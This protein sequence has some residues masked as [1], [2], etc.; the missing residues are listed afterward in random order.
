[1]ET[2]SRFG[3]ADRPGEPWRTSGRV[4]KTVVV[5]SWAW[6]LVWNVMMLLMLWDWLLLPPT[7]DPPMTLYPVPLV[8]Q[9]FDFL[10]GV[11]GGFLFY[12]VGLL[13]P[14]LLLVMVTLPWLEP[15]AR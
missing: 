9:V 15:P 14:I 2:D 1:M 11:A 5:L 4:H 3:G 6:A 10:F 13:S 7:D 8:E 12:L